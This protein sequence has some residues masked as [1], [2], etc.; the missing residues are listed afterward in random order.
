MRN[1]G[2]WISIG[3]FRS[4]KR[5]IGALETVVENLLASPVYELDSAHAF[6]GQTGR[7]RLF[8][9]I[10]E[11][12]TFECI[13]ET[14][15]FIGN[16]AGWMNQTT[17]RLPVYSCE[18]NRHFHLLARKR[19]GDQKDVRLELGDSVSFLNR[20]VVSRP[21]LQPVFFYL[22]AHWYESL[23]LAAELRV[24]ARHWQD[25]VVMVDDFEVPW[26]NGY[27]FDDYGF[28]RSLT[29][30][31]FGKLFRELDLVAYSPTLPASQET[32]ARSGC[33]VLANEGSSA[34]RQLE[35][36]MLLRRSSK[37]TRRSR[38]HNSTESEGASR[39]QRRDTS[40]S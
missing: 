11:R 12:V 23:P 2:R 19:L 15:T 27:G 33:V 20:L 36:V 22:D 13:I 4:L 31:C 24:I 40:A 5:R 3:Y 9:E 34:A 35:L 30:A 8:A 6:N 37:G 14:G 1:I 10:T 18:I 16:T 25:F 38:S 17:G 32:G 21:W 7:Q 29:F 26:D 39:S 28:K